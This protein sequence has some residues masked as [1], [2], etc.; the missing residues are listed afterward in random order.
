[1]RSLQPLQPRRRPAPPA[2]PDSGR[3]SSSPRWSRGSTSRRPI[4]CSRCGATSDGERELGALRWGLMPGRWAERGGRPLINARAETVETQP[5]FR[6][7]FRERRCLIPADGFYEWR[8]TSA[9]SGRSGSAAPTASCSRSPA[10]GPSCRARAATGVLHSCAI[11]TCEPNELIRPIHD[12]MPVILDPASEAAWLDPEAEPERRCVE[13]LGPAP[14]DLLVAPRGRRLR[15]QRARGRPAPDRAPRGAAQPVLERRRALG[16]RRRCAG[17]R[18]S[19]RRSSSP[20]SGTPP[21]GRSSSTCHSWLKPIIATMIRSDLDRE[22]GSAS[23]GPSRSS[24]SAGESSP[25]L[26][27]ANQAGAA[28]GGE[29]R[30]D[31]RQRRGDGQH[32]AVPAQ[33]R[34]AKR[35]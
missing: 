9:A 28:I 8:A 11:V 7:S 29:D 23:A 14:E 16:R 18:R 15:Q 10:S 13:L 33:D 5:A 34:N 4:R 32:A 1:M 31:D 3:A 24:G 26:A 27:R 20:A 6:E 30:E 12:R 25:S 2:L 19:A 17:G 35:M 22:P 21:I